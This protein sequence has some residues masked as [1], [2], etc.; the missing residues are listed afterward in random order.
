MLLYTRIGKLSLLQHPTENSSLLIHA[1]QQE[2]VDRVVAMLDEIGGHCHEVQPIQE[3]DFRFEVVASKADVAQAV[4]RLVAE[5]NYLEFMR[6]LR[7][8]FGT[9][10]GFM[11][12]VTPNGLEV[13]RVKTK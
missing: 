7:I 4:A 9:D 11:L 5:I 3:G 1:D 2:G 6:T 8:T 12:T 10:P 13:A